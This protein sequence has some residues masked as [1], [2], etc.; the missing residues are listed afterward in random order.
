MA[1]PNT[2]NHK[3]FFI[4]SKN[5]P[6]QLSE[7]QDGE[8]ARNEEEKTWSRLRDEYGDR[9]EKRQVLNFVF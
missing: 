3:E 8:V 6:F 1:I 7:E 9:K 2:Q 4:L 5:S